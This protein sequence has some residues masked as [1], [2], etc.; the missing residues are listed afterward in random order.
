MVARQPNLGL[1]ALLSRCLDRSHVDLIGLLGLKLTL[2]LH[3]DLVVPRS[4]HT[5]S[6][7]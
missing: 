3:K 6:R 2:I 7:L 5:P 4:K 1:G